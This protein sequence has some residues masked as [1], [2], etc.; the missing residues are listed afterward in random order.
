LP[1][2]AL[3]AISSVFIS[4]SIITIFHLEYFVGWT[5]KDN[6]E[7]FDILSVKNFSAILHTRGVFITITIWSLASV[8]ICCERHFPLYT[9]YAA[10]RFTCV[11][12]SALYHC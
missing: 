3:G 6:L 5:K 10:T 9:V 11:L 8:H 1:V 4:A 12:V 7:L 2:E